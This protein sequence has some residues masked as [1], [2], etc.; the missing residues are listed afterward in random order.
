MS[1]LHETGLYLLSAMPCI[2]PEQRR[3]FQCLLKACCHL[4]R[5]RWTSVDLEK[6]K[7]TVLMAV[8]MVECCLPLNEM[9]MKLHAL[10]HLAEKVLATGP[11][12]N[13]CMFVYESL[14]GRMT[15]WARNQNAPEVS[16][17]HTFGAYETT[18]LC[19]MCNP[20]QYAYVTPHRFKDEEFMEAR[21]KVITAES[22]R[23]QDVKPPS[24][25][26]KNPDKWLTR[27]LHEYYMEWDTRLVGR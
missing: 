26:W 2:G 14:W 15:R 13:T 5:K 12:W 7:E 16:M 4:Q 6:L 25:V 18:F 19:F 24:L 17:V 8:A 11:L 1:V 20:R 22:P 3:A 21:Y 10:I 9:D 27:G 23:H